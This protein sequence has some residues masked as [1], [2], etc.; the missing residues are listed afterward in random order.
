MEAPALWMDAT[1]GAPPLGK[2]VLDVVVSRK[3]LRKFSGAA[4]LAM[5]ATSAA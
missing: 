3:A 2:G 4:P 1:E 5:R